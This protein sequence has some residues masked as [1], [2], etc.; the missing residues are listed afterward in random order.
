MSVKFFRIVSAGIILVFLALLWNEAAA[1]R[2]GGRAGGR[3]GGYSRVGPA[4]GGSFSS[5]SGGTR[6]GARADRTAARSDVRQDRQSNR[7]D[8]ASDRQEGASERA[9]TR[10][11]TV[12][13]RQEN[14]QDYVSDRQDDRMDYREDAR[15]DWQDY[16]DDRYWDHWRGGSGFAAGVAIGTAI[17]AA[18]FS[19][20]SCSKTVTLAGATYYNCGTSWYKRAYSGGSV[21]YVVVNPPPGY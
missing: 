2:G 6:Q 9:S 12:T 4:S 3:G 13:D 19:S 11:D 16:Y 21:T 18:S 10:Q 7:T 5:R 17:S 8:R 15:E 1:R 20:L 14:R